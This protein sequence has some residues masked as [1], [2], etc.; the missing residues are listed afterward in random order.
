M[1]LQKIIYIGVDYSLPE[2][3]NFLGDEVGDMSGHS[4]RS[5]CFSIVAC[6]ALCLGL[7]AIPA[8]AQS[9]STG[10]VVGQ[11]LDPQG[12]AV[13]GAVVTLIDKSTN[14][15]RSTTSNDTGRYI[16]IDV[17]PSNYDLTVAKDGFSQTKILNQTVTVGQQLTL[18]V[19]LKVGAASETVEVTAAL[20][21]QLQT[22][23]ATVGETVTG[24]SLTLLP[25]FG[26]DASTLA[27]LQPATNPSGETAG[28]NYDQNSF[29]L[30][31]AN[32][33]N[34]MDGSMNIYTP[35]FGS[36]SAASTSTLTNTSVPTGVLP[37]PVE[38]IEEFKTNTNNQT[39]DFVGAAGAQVMMVTKK[40]TDTFHGTAYWYYTDSVFGGANTWDNN[41][42]GLP[43]TSNHQNRFGGNA[44]G[45]ISKNFMGGK[46]YLFGEYD[47]RRY[48]NA[49]TFT[50]SVPT[51]TLRAGVVGIRTTQNGVNTV[52]YVNTNSAPVTVGGVTYP[53]STFCGPAG[54]QTC[55]PLGLGINPT[56]SSIWSTYMPLPNESHGG[57]TINTLGYASVLS[58]PQTDNFGVIRLDHDFG[59]KWHWNLVYN[60][61]HLNNTTASQVDIG[62]FFPGDTFGQARA[63]SARPQVPNLYSTELTWNVSNN[64]T[65]DLHVSYLRNFW[66]WVDSGIPPQLGNLG[67]VLEPGGETS[68]PQA[69]YNV[70]NQ[71][72]RTRFWD[73]QDKM[74]RDDITILHGNHLL[75]LGGLYQRNYLQHQ[76]NDN[77][78]TI[79]DSPFPV[80]LSTNA[81]AVIDYTNAL[82]QPCGVIQTNCLG[83]DTSVANYERYYDEALGILSQ[84]QDLYPRTGN[85]L[86]VESLGT[87]ALEQS[88]VSTYN[89]YFTDSWHLKPS[90]T[91]TYGLGYQIELP[92]YEIN[93]TQITMVDQNDVPIT[94]EQYLSETYQAGIK[95]QIYNPLIGFASVKNVAG[96]K[97]LGGEKYPYNPFYKGLSPRISFA[98]NPTYDSGFMGN[99]LGHGKTVVRAGY[100]RIYGR[101]NGVDL[102]LVPLL[103]PGFLQPVVC[104]G[105]VGYGPSSGTCAGTTGVK[106]TPSTAFRIG[107]PTAGFSGF[108]AP[109]PTVATNLPQPF[110]PGV[111][112]QASAGAGEAL[113]P[114]FQPSHS[115]EID[116][117]IQ[118]ELPG[119]WI[120]EV[121]Y[122]GRRLRNEYQPINISAVPYMLTLG[123]QTFA[124]AWA[125]MYNEVNQGQ[126]IAAQPWFES[127]LGGAGSPYCHQNMPGTMTPFASCTQAVSVLEN[128]NINASSGIAPAVYD[129]WQDLSPNFTFGRSMP[130]SPNCV[131]QLVPSI[132]STNPV[133]VCQQV[134]GI[135]INTTLGYGN[136]NGVFVS[137]TSA[138]WHG[139]TARSNF[140]WG[141][142]L[143]TQSTV[144]ATSEFTVPDPWD[145][146]NGYGPQPFDIRFLYNL[147]MLYQPAWFKGQHD[148]K[149]HLLGGWSFAPLFTARS[150]QPLAVNVG[151]GNGADCQG[152]GESDCN[153]FAS[154]EGAV[155]TGNSAVNTAR[156]AGTTTHSIVVSGLTG[157]NGNPANGGAGLNEFANPAAV[158][159]SFRA[160]ILGIDHNPASFAMRGL[161][162]WNLDFTLS[163][164]FSITER[165]GIRFTV[166]VTNIL[167]HNQLGDPFLEVNDPADFGVLG[168][169]ISPPR[170]MEFGLRFHF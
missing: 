170:Q 18:E 134:N 30:N 67:G 142:S 41:F 115:D 97:A 31:G 10:T 159:S 55:D 83:A 98:W 44:G 162:T 132:N 116:L 73:G 9:V 87:P 32:N 101:L 39:A 154:D 64:V 14:T 58:L 66:Q 160:P 152:F 29:M 139:L 4:W 34:D 15:P 133:P 107:D 117:T 16:F 88:V 5:A 33:T 99:L 21:A 108:T 158:Y 126:P 76:R 8:M 166:Q 136:Y 84:T 131:N 145:L 25:N 22:M 42:N 163:K 56:M 143:G 89:M 148:W 118:R 43:I 48:P 128:S 12:A 150:G 1:D 28:A 69:P 20:G 141:R 129:T 168:G 80:Y 95:G 119:R 86:T 165:M 78:G 60:Y 155:F 102:I 74:V 63:Q 147:T 72:T 92:P 103:A 65:N 122:I 94:T 6:L 57:D 7:I 13:V 100:S 124:Q 61:Y 40:G 35:S 127:A 110:F 62:G 47:G 135:G 27:T 49:E 23:N 53:V 144:Q 123:G 146:H 50:A 109:L 81:S 106:A 151:E 104:Q 167:N 137:L 169:E 105:P 138:D 96:E 90:F 17:P 153:F 68:T 3:P 52:Q 26:R 111:A 130:S 2:S 51:A 24:A 93:G 77:G 37:T 112:G 164:E 85:L 149:G 59:S 71:S 11:V 120:M 75:Q 54:N 114:D 45:P 157:S 70:N 19:K 156:G 36:S 38:S 46:W 82:P 121:G 161:S 79:Q 125:A 91:L 140:T 113:D